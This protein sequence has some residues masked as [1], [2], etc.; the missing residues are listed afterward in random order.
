[1][2]ELPEVETIRRQ[3]MPHLP[4]KVLK[5]SVSKVASSIIKT[6]MFSP[7]GRTLVD[8]KRVG[9]VMDFVFDDGHHL[10]SGL[11]MSGAWRYSKTP[12]NEPHTH[13]H[14]T[15]QN[16]QGTIYIAYVDPRRFGKSHFL[17]EEE[18]AKKLSALGVDIGSED[19][20]AG[21]VHDLCQR[22][23]NKEIKPFLLEQR[24][25]AGIGNYIA[26]EICAHARILPTRKAGSL[27]KKECEGIVRGAQLV[28]SGSLK[29]RGL[30]FAGGYTDAT[31]QKGEALD[32]L[33]VFHQKICGLCEKTEVV[34][35]ELK[36]RGTFY[37]P[38]C[39]K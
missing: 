12:I 37:C 21:Y 33:V 9:K 29:K 13:I 30:T 16:K 15:C 35:I 19:F 24:Y 28:L 14:F 38:K 4:A 36:G 27:S 1:M 31:G 5:M 34:K 18:A 25:F 11:G 2:P 17:D 10:I 23:P 3:L 22:F 32:N 20:T 26:C 7:V 6:E 39:Q 8:I